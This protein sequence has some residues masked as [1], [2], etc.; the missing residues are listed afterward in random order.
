MLKL[1][2]TTSDVVLQ[3]AIYNLHPMTTSVVESGT[4]SGI[5]ACHNQILSEHALQTDGS[6]RYQSQEPRKRECLYACHCV[7]ASTGCSS[8]IP[9]GPGGRQISSGPASSSTA[10][11]P[12]W[13]FLLTHDAFLYVYVRHTQIHF[14]IFFPITCANS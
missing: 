10:R 8:S 13:Y 14:V 3:A 6:Q 7:C 2:K 4:R 5:K 1:Q 11:S 12:C 9:A